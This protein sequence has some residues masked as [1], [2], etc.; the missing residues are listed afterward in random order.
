MSGQATVGPVGFGGCQGRVVFF[1][2]AGSG[3]V[4]GSHLTLVFPEGPWGLSWGF[5]PDRPMWSWGCISIGLKASVFF[6]KGGMLACRAL[7]MRS[8]CGVRL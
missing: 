3:M 1:G 8:Y 7:A 6:W 2:A 4:L 5:G